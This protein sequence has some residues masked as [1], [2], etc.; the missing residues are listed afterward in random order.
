MILMMRGVEAAK[1]DTGSMLMQMKED[2]ESNNDMPMK[3]SR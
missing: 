2:V 1:E 3:Q